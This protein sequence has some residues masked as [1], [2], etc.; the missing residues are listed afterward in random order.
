[1]CHLIGILERSVR[2]SYG[3]GHSVRKRVK[4][5]VALAVV[6]QPLELDALSKSGAMLL[7]NSA[8]YRGRQ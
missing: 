8:R 1:M 7:G 4:N 3:L 5:E 6:Y 2:C